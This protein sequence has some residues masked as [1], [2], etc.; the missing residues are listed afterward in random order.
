LRP[1]Q[2]PFRSSAI[3]QQRFRITDLDFFNLLQVIERQNFLACIRGPHGTGKSTLL[4]DVARIFKKQG[5]TVRW[6]YLNQDMSKAQKRSTL[7]EIL[8]SKGDTINFLDGGE[9]IGY[10]AWL[11]FCWRA[12]QLNKFLLATTHTVSPLTTIYK[13]HA[14]KNLMLT[15]TKNLAGDFWCDGMRS[16]AL[17]AFQHYNGN[18]R[19]VFRACYFFCSELEK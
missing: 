15:I 17:K 9:T 3:A 7:Q 16:Q 11:I 10:G 1:S 5:K 4:E 19:E 13:T 12:K 6:H 14:D 8:N 18:F 2:N